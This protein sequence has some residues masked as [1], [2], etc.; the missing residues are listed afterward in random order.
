MLR[1]VMVLI[2]EKI[3][4][5]CYM[6]VHLFFYTLKNN[7][8]LSYRLK[9]DILNEANVVLTINIYIICKAEAK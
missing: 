2:S 8:P 3:E 4:Q 5:K 9:L 6:L 1:P 7:S